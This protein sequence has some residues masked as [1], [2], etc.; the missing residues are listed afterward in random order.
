MD[1]CQQ[2]KPNGLAKL[3]LSFQSELICMEIG[4]MVDETTSIICCFY[5]FLST[6]VFTSL[7][8]HRNAMFFFRF[9]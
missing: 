4:Q 8:L 6:S 2:R 1:V 3:I 9:S 7:C 5:F